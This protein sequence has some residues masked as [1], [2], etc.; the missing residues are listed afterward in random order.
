MNKSPYSLFVAFL[1]MFAGS[2]I[3]ADAIGNSGSATSLRSRAIVNLK[4]VDRR[5]GWAIGRID[6]KAVVLYTA[7]SCRTW[8]IVSPMNVSIPKLFESDDVERI[9]FDF[10]GADEAWFSFPGKD[11]QMITIHTKDRGLHWKLSSFQC[12][13]IPYYSMDLKFYNRHHGIMLLYVDYATGGVLKALY[14]THDSGTHWKLISENCDTHKPHCI[15]LYSANSGIEFASATTLFITG[16]SRIYE[17]TIALYKSTDGGK[18][19]YQQYPPYPKQHSRF[20]YANSYHPL[21]KGATGMMPV[22]FVSDK[23][24][25]FTLYRTTDR[26]KHWKKA[27]YLKL[28]SD[29]FDYSFSDIN[30]CW[31]IDID[32]YKLYSTSDYGRNWRFIANTPFLNKHRVFQFQFVKPG[33][34]WC[35]V[36]PSTEET[37]LNTEIYA[38]SD[39]GKRWRKVHT[40][41]K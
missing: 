23:P 24:A 25:Y 30:H 29:Y 39:S 10:H 27:Q 33:Y 11:N 13:Y 4:M 28:S 31:V 40:Q 20:R 2:S 37:M 5:H 26:G 32:N 14:E 18:K 36:Y 21:F 17:D 6:H 19:W 15:P 8:K 41:F 38:T 34:G 16:G 7:D 22:L 1:F 35:I 12:K 3:C 9:E